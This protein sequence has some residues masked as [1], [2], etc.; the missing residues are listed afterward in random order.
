MGCTDSKAQS[1]PAPPKATSAAASKPASKPAASGG[2]KLIVKYFDGIRGRADPIRFLLHHANVDY[3]YVGLTFPE[4][5]A[6]K[7]S[8]QCPEFSGLPVVIMDG[9]EYG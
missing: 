9:V 8:P 6:L 7:G 5:G 2:K 1:N 3:E 4:W